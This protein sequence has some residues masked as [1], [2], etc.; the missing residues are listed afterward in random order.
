M[1]I[2]LESD[3][4]GS[5]LI[6]AAVSYLTGD[7]LP[8]TVSSSS[9]KASVLSLDITSDG[10]SIVSKPQSVVVDSSENEIP[11][12]F[13]KFPPSSM[14]YNITV[15]ATLSHGNTEIT[16]ETSTEL[17]RLPQRTDGGSATR[18]D[19]LYGGLA[20]VKGDQTS[21]MPIFPYTYYGKL[22]HSDHYYQTRKWKESVAKTH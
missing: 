6:D 14:P 20:V 11:I 2:Y 13:D 8:S 18:L 9:N 22:I 21:W 4:E 19:H 15:R 17:Y 10:T 1:S 5:L 12:S 7:P 16:F 3:S